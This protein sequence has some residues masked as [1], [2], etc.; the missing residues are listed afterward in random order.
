[1]LA[2]VLVLVLGTALRLWPRIVL[3]NAIVSD[4]YFHLFCARA[5]RAN[6]MR[7]PDRL[8]GIVLPHRYTY[9][10]LYSWL[11]ALFPERAWPWAERATGAVFDALNTVIVY[12]F[13]QWAVQHA[14]P[15]GALPAHLIPL[16]AA[17]L[18][19]LNPALLRLGSGPR[20]YAGSPRVFGQTLYLLHLTTAAYALATGSRTALAICVVSCAA[21]FVVAKFGIQV[22]VFFGVP[23]ALLVSPWYAAVVGAGLVLAVAAT[24]GR[25]WRVLEGQVRHSWFYA[26]HLQRR[27]LE[28]HLRKPDDYH[29]HRTW[30]WRNFRNTRKAERLIRWSFD[31]T[32]WPHLLV[33]VF[34]QFLLLPAYFA[35]GAWQSPFDAF[36]LVWAG[37]GLLWFFLTKSRRLLFL[38]E[39][40]RYLEYALVPSLLLLLR[41]VPWWGLAPLG[42]YTLYCAAASAFHA[43]L[44]VERFRA[45]NDEAPATLEAFARLNSL[46]PGAVLPLGSH[47]WR[48]AYHVAF[49]I[50]THGANVDE[51]LLSL[52]EFALVL[53]NYPYPSSDIEGVLRRY[54]VAYLVTDEISLRAFIERHLGGDDR[55]SPMLDPIWRTPSL[56]LAHVRR[57]DARAYPREQAADGVATAAVRA[58]S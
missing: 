14:P 1:M 26:R 6:R 3:P 20:A 16:A 55:L 13:A 50:V 43:R 40:E 45:A 58:A 15:P 29:Q 53:G 37:A 9:P 4:T 7:V 23:F 42:L 28:P 33:T 31:E 11:L 47:H 25:A 36:L 39:G 44:F 57:D 51:R 21:T 52:D 38:G 18:Y 27:Y 54:D 8:P 30:H 49:P 32:Y 56:V 35:A 34:P 17:T 12:A 46:T 19:A 5:I 22:L 2:L 48:A 24:A 10:F 41:Y